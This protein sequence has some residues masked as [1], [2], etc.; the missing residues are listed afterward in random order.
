M[1]HYRVLLGHKTR[2]GYISILERNETS[3]LE[4]FGFDYMTPLQTCKSCDFN[5][6]KLD[7]IGE[8]IDND[9]ELWKCKDMG[10]IPNSIS[11][12]EASKK[13]LNNP[14]VTLFDTH[15]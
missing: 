1:T 5:K 12:I 10:H 11:R 15:L 2:D 14:Y 6:D 4:P 9:I 8:F 3:Y 7:E 13:V